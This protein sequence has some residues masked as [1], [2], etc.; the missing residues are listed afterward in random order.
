MNGNPS[1]KRPTK[2]ESL[3]TKD[4]KHKLKKLLVEKWRLGRKDGQRK[5]NK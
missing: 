4:L 2:E 3:E 1:G 5:K